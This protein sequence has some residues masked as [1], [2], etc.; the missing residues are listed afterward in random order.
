MKS[1]SMKIN[2]LEFIVTY[3]CSGSCKHCSAGDFPRGS[4]AHSIKPLKAA[5]AV[6]S[7]SE[8]YAIDSVMTFGGE[9]LLYPDV[10]CAAHEAANKLGIGARQLITNGYF[11]KDGDKIEETA[12]KLSGSGVNDLLLSVDAFHQQTIPLGVVRRF[13]ESALRQGL[14]IRF[15]PAW[16]VDRAHENPYNKRTEAILESLSDLGIETSSGNNI[17]LAGNAA[18]YL[19]EFYPEERLDLSVACGEMPY[20]SALDDIDSLTIEP[21][22]DVT[23]CAF[24]IGNI[25]DEDLGAIARRYN[26][27]DNACMSIILSEGVAGLL[28]HARG[29]GIELDP[30]TFS[31]ACAL[32]RELA[33]RL[34]KEKA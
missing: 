28:R 24:V 16:V 6:R 8:L 2:R 27:R 26:P 15:H 29:S 9:P 12:R 33:K 34:A 17:F 4:A 30:S 7:L 1:S 32:C 25:N 23:V 31:S 13:A 21:N 22:G 14:R 11:S 18:K 10:V 19:A 5:E 3:D 20:T